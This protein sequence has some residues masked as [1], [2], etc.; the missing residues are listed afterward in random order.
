M[1]NYRW[2]S[3]ALF[4]FDAP[5]T[6]ILTLQKLCSTQP[7]CSQIVNASNYY[8]RQFVHSQLYYET[9][10]SISFLGV[11]GEV[12][13][14]NTSN[15]RVD[16][17]NYIVKNI[18]SVSGQRNSIDYISVSKWSTES[19]QW[20]YYRNQS[21]IIVWPSQTKTVPVNYKLIRGNQ[22]FSFLQR[23]DERGRIRRQLSHP[24]L[25]YFIREPHALSIV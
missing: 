1:S 22:M 21:D 14:S 24:H 19:S 4:T 23:R 5:W 17:F 8:Y 15:D 7:S 13:F 6:L 16:R 12:R 10:R 18:Q 2:H 11:T 9:M 20:T 25:S 3:Y